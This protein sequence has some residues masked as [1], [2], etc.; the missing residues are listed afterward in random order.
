MKQ[1]SIRILAL[2]C[3]VLMIAALAA[4]K[5]SD[6]NTGD[7]NDAA[8]SAAEG[9]TAATAAPATAAPAAP[10][11]PAAALVGKWQGDQLGVTAIYTFNADGTGSYT[12]AGTELPITYTATD[13]TLS[14]SIEG[15]ESLDQPYKLEGDTLTITPTVDVAGD[16]VLTRVTQ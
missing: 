12:V 10:A 2:L 5:K 4:C 14:I 1:L 11:N 13:T 8:S 16:L 15:S 7:N 3:A 9:N 6:D